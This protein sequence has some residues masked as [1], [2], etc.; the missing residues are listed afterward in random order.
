M[1][2][3]HLRMD[4]QSINDMVIVVIYFIIWVLMVH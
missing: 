2:E 4:N 3:A 1:V